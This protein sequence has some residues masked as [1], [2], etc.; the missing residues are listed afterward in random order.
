MER[1]DISIVGRA[2]SLGRVEMGEGKPGFYRWA[3]G[4]VVAGALVASGLLTSHCTAAD[5]ETGG[6]KSAV[7]FTCDFESADWFK[8]WGV[9]RTPQNCEL[10]A[11]DAE[12]KFEPW[13]GKALRIKI[14]QGDHYGTSIEYRFQ[15][16]HGFEPE[17]IYFRYYLRLGHDW[18][19]T[20]GGKLPGVAGTYGRAGWG[21]R[22]VDGTDGWSARGLFE[23]R[24]EGKTAVGFYCYHMDMRGRYGSQWLWNRDGLGFLDNN[25]WYCL[26]QHVKLNTPGKADGVMR[27]WVDGQ[28]VFE[29][30]DVRMRAVAKLRIE[31]VWLNVYY[32]GT[33][34]APRDMHLY[35]DDVAISREPIGPAQ[36]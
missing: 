7:L 35:I 33:W 19:A 21:G 18:T 16:Q 20:R 22:P 29:K 36:R 30:T 17:E 26:E 11:A 1:I 4:V 25:R 6:V 9:R 23:G 31:M 24:T 32:G 10:V 3:T 12:R 8:A 15:R 2:K 27:G 34:T 5:A 14:N 13:V 28:L